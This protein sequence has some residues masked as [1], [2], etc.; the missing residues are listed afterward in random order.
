MAW[1]SGL[2]EPP[3]AITDPSPSAFGGPERKYHT[4]TTA[5]GKGTQW[6]ARVHY[7]WFKK[8]QRAC[9]EQYG[10]NCQM[11]GFTRLLHSGS[12]DELSEEIPTYVVSPLPSGSNSYIV[13]SREQSES[14]A[15]Q[16]FCHATCG[17]VVNCCGW[18]DVT[19]CLQAHDMVGTVHNVR[20][21]IAHSC[22]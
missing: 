7:Y 13:R 16:L 17:R 5:Q 2:L 14:H 12:D 22:A 6:Q 15:L 1:T 11:G 4:V 3:E 18:L 8:Q 20:L 19:W 9:R 10:I 21:W